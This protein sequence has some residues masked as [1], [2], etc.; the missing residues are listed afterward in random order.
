[1]FYS[2][3]IIQANVFDHNKN[4]VSIHVWRI[5]SS[6]R[7]FWHLPDIDSLMSFSLLLWKTKCNISSINL[8]QFFFSITERVTVLLN[9]SRISIG[10]KPNSSSMICNLSTG[11]S[12]WSNLST[13]HCNITKQN[14]DVSDNN[15]W[16]E[17][18]PLNCD[19]LHNS[20]ICLNCFSVINDGSE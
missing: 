7:S 11:C 16:S 18:F 19:K 4:S 10:L 9:K 15:N 12:I 17:C 5:L 2:M 8:P 1:M 3:H 20:A 6:Y 13:I 14:R